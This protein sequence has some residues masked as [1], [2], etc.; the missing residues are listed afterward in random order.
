M[1]TRN[2]RDFRPLHARL[3]SR[4]EAHYGVIFLPRSQLLAE[5]GI[6][7]VVRALHRLLIA[8]TADET[9]LSQERWLTPEELSE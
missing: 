3:M 5:E 1:V 2:V 6:G 9:L 8:S 7:D 4:G